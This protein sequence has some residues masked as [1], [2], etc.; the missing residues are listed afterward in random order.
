VNVAENGRVGAHHHVVAEGG[1]AL[2]AVL[3]GHSERDALIDEAIVADDGRSSDDHADAMVDREPATDLCGGK[4]VGAK[5]A[6][7]ALGEK[8]REAPHAVQVEP[9][10][11]A[12]RPHDAR[13]GGVEADVPERLRRRVAV[14][15]SLRVLA[16]EGEKR[17][18]VVRRAAHQRS[19]ER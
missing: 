11:P 19:M 13:A 7:R 18:V 6:S 8:E 15:G 5:P 4:D 10:V 12:I 9:A 14:K 16:H 17:G 2:P 3:A 1:V